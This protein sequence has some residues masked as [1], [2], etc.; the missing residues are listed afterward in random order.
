[1]ATSRTL[2]AK[3]GAV[4]GRHEE[5]FDDVAV[6]VVDVNW[7]IIDARLQIVQP[8]GVAA[9]IAVRWIV[10]R[11]LQ[12]D[13]VGQGD[14]IPVVIEVRRIKQ[15]EP[16]GPRLGAE[17]GTV[18]E[19]ARN[20]DALRIDAW[21]VPPASVDLV[22]PA[23]QLRG[24]GLAIEEIQILLRNE[25]ARAVN[26]IRTRLRREMDCGC[27]QKDQEEWKGA[28]PSVSF[29]DSTSELFCLCYD[30]AA[31]RKC[32][33]VRLSS[34]PTAV[35]ISGDRDGFFPL[36]CPIGAPPIGASRIPREVPAVSPRKGR[37]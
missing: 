8:E 33:A 9:V 11:P 34:Q 7:R 24:R 36:R 35:T 12:I 23:V 32:K 22:D 20:D 25:E 28:P 6:A 14:E 16:E 2:A 26:R 1:M 13:V 15:R 30:F 21:R 18:P 37:P 5:R 3:P 4:L 19:R 27:Q 17:L 10:R 29:H 31:Q